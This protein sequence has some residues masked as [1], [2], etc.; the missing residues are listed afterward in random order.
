MNMITPVQQ[1]HPAGGLYFR[2]GTQILIFPLKYTEVKA[3]IAGN[4]SRVQVAQ[5]FENPFNKTL[6]AVYIF[7]LPE[8][9]ETDAIEIKI[10]DRTIKYNLKIDQESESTSELTSN[11]QQ[12]VS[13]LKQYWQNIFTQHLADIKPGDL[14]VITICYTDCL[15]FVGEDCNEV[16]NGDYE[17][18]LP[19][20]V[21][22][23]YFSPSQLNGNRNL[24]QLTKAIVINPTAT[25]PPM[26]RK[27]EINLTVEINSSIGITNLHSTSHAIK[28]A[29]AGQIVRI[30]LTEV[31]TIPNQD[32]RLRYQI[33]GKEKPSKRS[34]ILPNLA[35]EILPQEKPTNSQNSSQS[36]A[37]YSSKTV[38]TQ[39]NSNADFTEPVAQEQE[40]FTL[41][42]T[43]GN[44]SNQE[45]EEDLNNIIAALQPQLQIVSITGLDEAVAAGM[46]QHLMIVNLPS[47]LSGELVFNFIVD[48]SGRVQQ[49][50]WEQET[51]TFKQAAVI[52]LIKQWLSTWRA[53][54][55][56]NSSVRLTLRIE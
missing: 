3:K 35:T 5:T 14:I 13:L 43:D 23:S 56:I 18:V 20:S 49:I 6:D 28:I 2:I 15:K 17:F 9:A 46:M 29:Q 51:S 38:P 4:V 32:L 42:L 26:R 27:N 54:S 1:N 37:T 36:Q 11:Q 55:G 19:M 8:E 40:S 30:Q 50:I 12:T 44:F 31:D 10:G 7:P 47:G 21:A 22:S 41:N 53:P 48:I 39:P 25:P 52:E 33:G 34:P 16:S 24:N 45:V